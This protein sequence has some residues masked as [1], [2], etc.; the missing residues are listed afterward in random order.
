M[1]KL[2]Y[3]FF[4][5]V[6]MYACSS[7]PQYKIKGNIQGIKSGTAYLQKVEQR[8]YITIDSVAIS[9]GKFV[10]KGVIEEPDFRIIKLADTLGDIPL[11]LENSQITIEANVDSLQ[12]TVVTGSE[13]TTKYYEFDKANINYEMQ[14]RNL[15]NE[16]MQANMSGDG[17]KVKEIETTYEQLENEQMDYIKQFVKNNSNMVVGPFIAAQYLMMQMEYQELDEIAKGFNP[18]LSTSRFVVMINDRIETMRR[19]AIGQPYTDFTLNDTTGNPVSLSSYIGQKYVLIDFW[20]AWCSPCR[21]ENPTLVANYAKYKNKGFEIF[22]VSFD[23]SRDAW[24]K[25]IHD[26]GITWPQVSDLKY[27]ECEAGKLYGVRGIPHNVLIDKD[28]IIIAKN[29]RGD[30]LGAKLEELFK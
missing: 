18:S 23:K 2:F 4:A 22:G 20:A 25:A 26:D 9:N 16:Y 15:Y 14:F 19:V 30:E 10:F 8:N 24:I 13:N 1:K 3:V 11:I 29:L 21:H 7:E 6:L 28:G 17:A 12:G 5:L 27:W